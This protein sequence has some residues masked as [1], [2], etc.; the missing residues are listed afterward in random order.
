MKC[1]FHAFP[2]SYVIVVML[3]VLIVTACGKEDSNITENETVYEVESVSEVESMSEMVS[4]PEADT[5]LLSESL[6]ESEGKPEETIEKEESSDSQ[7]E[8]EFF[9]VK[10]KTHE[11]KSEDDGYGNVRDTLTVIFEF[12]NITDQTFYKNDEE[13][14]S[15][16]VWEKTIYYPIEKWREYAENP[17]WIHYR[18]YDTNQ[19][20]IFSGGL[21]FEMD[22]DLNVIHTEI[23]TD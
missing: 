2:K 12:Q 19:N 21:Y 14:L 3:F 15:G 20:E 7:L 5:T 10:L 16:A 18:L 6:S 8:N 22:E 11:E 1:P 4:V 17:F 23:F 13:I 9:R